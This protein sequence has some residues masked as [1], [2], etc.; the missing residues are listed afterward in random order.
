MNKTAIC[1][2]GFANAYLA[3]AQ[4]FSYPCAESRNIFT[5]HELLDPTVS[6]ETLESEF[7]AVFELGKVCTTPATTRSDVLFFI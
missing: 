1:R 6:L 3:L 4:L 7:L 5:A 2:E